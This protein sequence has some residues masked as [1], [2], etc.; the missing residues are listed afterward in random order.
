MANFEPNRRKK[1]SSKKDILIEEHLILY[2][3][4]DFSFNNTKINKVEISLCCY[5]ELMALTSGSGK[6]EVTRMFHG[7]K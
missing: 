2:L 7:I 6:E 3:K 5:C 1:E 4:V